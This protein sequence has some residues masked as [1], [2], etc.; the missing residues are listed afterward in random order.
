M[1]C[2]HCVWGVREYSSNHFLL[3]LCT[4]GVPSIQRG[5]DFPFPLNLGCP[6]NSLENRIGEKRYLGNSGSSLKIRQ[7][8]FP[9][10]SL[11]SDLTLEKHRLDHYKKNE[12][13][14]REHREGC[15]V[16]DWSSLKPLDQTIHQ[17]KGTEPTTP[18]NA[19]SISQ[20]CLNSKFI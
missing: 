16:C 6:N 12:C 7:L 9:S 11:Q 17:V 18:V 19:L 10:S 15:S 1:G 13:E 5:V 4:H 3:S 8:N 2:S 14:E 20:S